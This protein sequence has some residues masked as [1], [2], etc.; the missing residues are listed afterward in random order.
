VDGIEE[1]MKLILAEAGTPLAAAD[2]L[3]RRN[4]HSAA[5]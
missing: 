5:G 4:L 1:T 2:R 3:A